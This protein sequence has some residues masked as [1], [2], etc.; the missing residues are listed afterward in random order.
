[1]Q[2]WQTYRN[3]DETEGRGPMVP[4]LAF[5]HRQHAE[6][7][8]D[9]QPGVMGRRGKWSLNQYG[10]WD[11]IPV[12]V[13]DYD[14]VELESDKEKVRQAALKKLSKEEKEALGLTDP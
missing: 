1:M 5:L 13:I 10:D 14:I 6:R 8:I 4:D 12:N 11:I 7:Y 9:E 2:I 3:A